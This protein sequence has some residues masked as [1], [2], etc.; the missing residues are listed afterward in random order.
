MTT[1]EV[2]KKDVAEKEISPINSWGIFVEKAHLFFKEIFLKMK[3]PY[4]W[5]QL[6]FKKNI[7]L[8]CQMNK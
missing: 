7:L 8:K 1:H 3:K 2:L 6:K 4:S 5:N